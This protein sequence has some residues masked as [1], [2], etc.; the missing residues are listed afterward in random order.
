MPGPALVIPPEPATTEA[1]VAV[2]ADPTVT[3]L[4]VDELPESVSRPPES[5]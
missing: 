4:A 3:V 2:A 5:V 1:I